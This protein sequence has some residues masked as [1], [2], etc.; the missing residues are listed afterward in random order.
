MAGRRVGYIQATLMVAGFILLVGFMVWFFACTFR[1]Q[2]TELS[3]AEFTVAYQRYAWA[4]WWG[5]GLSLAAW[6]WALVSSVQVLRESRPARQQ[7]MAKT[8]TAS[9]PKG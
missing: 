2:M 7:P 3:K 9:H 5:L 8:T 4:G 1:Y 6:C